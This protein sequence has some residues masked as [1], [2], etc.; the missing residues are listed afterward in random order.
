MC[1]KIGLT[2]VP[3]YTAIICSYFFLFFNTSS[4]SSH[5]AQPPY[6][7]KDIVCF[8]Q[9]SFA[10]VCESTQ[11]FACKKGRKKTARGTIETRV[12]KLNKNGRNCVKRKVREEK[13][14]KLRKG[15]S[16]AGS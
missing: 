1:L 8:L 13:G 2:N 16:Y 4:L 12:Q 15:D 10:N 14:E 5:C 11:V 7:W 9:T 3:F 6:S